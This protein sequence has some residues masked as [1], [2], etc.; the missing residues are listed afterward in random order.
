[1]KRLL[2]IVFTLCYCYLATAQVGTWRNYLAYHDVQQICKADNE[3][4]VLASN[5]LYQY[6]INDAS[7]TTYDKVNGLSDTRITHIAWNQ[8][9]KR[10][11]AIYDNSNIDLIEPD[12]DIINI[13]A[14]YNKSI[15]E[16][17]TVT[18]ISIDDVYAYL[19]TSFAIIKVNMLK[20]EISETYT[21]NHPEYPYDLKPY[22]DDYDK[23]IAT[24]STLNPNG[25]AYNRFYESKFIGDKLYTT[26]GYFLPAMPDNALPGTIQVFDGNDWTLYQEQINEITGYP[27]VDIC[28]VD[29]DPHDPEHVFAG[30]RCGLYEFKNGQ[31]ITYYN[32]DNSPLMG[33]NDR[34][35]LLG[36]DYVLVLGILFDSK[37]SLWVLNSL[38]EGVSLLELTSDHQWISHHHTELED[39]KGI[40]IP[41]LSKMMFDSHG[42]LWFVNNFWNIPALFCY[43]TNQDVILKYDQIV[44]QDN[45]KYSPYHINCIAEDKEGNIWI[46]TD[47]GPFMIQENEIGQTTVTFYQVKVPRNDGTNYADYLF[48]N[49]DI[50]SMAID[51]ANRKWFGTNGAGVFL[52][53]SDNMEQEEN[54]TTENSNLLYNNISSISINQQ[55]GEVFFLSDNGLCSYQSNAIAPSQEMTKDHISVYPNPVTPDYTGLVTITGLTYDADVKITTATGAIVAEGRSNGGMFNWDCRNK[56]GK[57]VASGVYMIITATSDGKKGTVGKIAVIN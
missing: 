12:G 37:G 15:T 6:N 29:V 56:Q 50:S 16:D 25:P 52:I 10:L 2:A 8:K 24:V 54:F 27:Y 28:C 36:N 35:T 57:R 26:G 53:S 44:N 51:G 18:D 5:D 45:T 1:M 42:L 31:L 41:G 13:S 32:K 39:E 34:G 55:S 40:T 38:A 19:T 9:A 11:I 20:A 48:N 4:F 7:I 49:V 30:G 47:V 43:D 14:L 33:A 22:Q 17:K 46:G 3:L 23:Y 21:K